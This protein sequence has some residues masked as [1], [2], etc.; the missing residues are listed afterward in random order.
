MGV[1]YLRC[2]LFLTFCKGPLMVTWASMI[3]RDISNRARQPNI[4]IN[5]ERLWTYMADSFRRQY[6]DTQEKE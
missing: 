4:R 1:P 5:D 6:A 2:M 3:A